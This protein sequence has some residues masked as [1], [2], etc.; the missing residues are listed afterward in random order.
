MTYLVS[1]SNGEGKMMQKPFAMAVDRSPQILLVGVGGCGCSAIEVIKH[2]QLAHQVTLAAVNTDHRELALTMIAKQVP[3]GKQLTKGLGAGAQPSLGHAAAL[4]NRTEL[5]ELVTGHDLVMVI[6]GGGGGTGTGATPVLLDVCAELSIPSVAFVIKPFVFEGAK[7]RKFAQN[8]IEHSHQ[9]AGTTFVFENDRLL[10][11]LGKDV[12]LEQALDAANGHIHDLLYGLVSMMDADAIAHVDF[13]HLRAILG[14]HR[15][16]QGGVIE[17][18]SYSEIKD[19]LIRF[20]LMTPQS[21]TMTM[22]SAPQ[23]LFHAWVPSD[24]SLGD[25][26]QIG[27]DLSDCFQYQAEITA[28]MSIWQEDGVK[29]VLLVCG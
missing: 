18:K 20:P 6:A 24:F 5:L 15:L 1:N 29:I 27:D 10:S 28:G 9:L 22:E 7:R 12:K 19:Q 21:N 14:Q 11:V 25:F 4:E 16:G 3:I 17:G 13:S 8:L 2:T 23:I 26:A